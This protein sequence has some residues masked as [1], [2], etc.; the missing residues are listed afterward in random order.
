[1]ADWWKVRTA[2]DLSNFTDSE[3]YDDSADTIVKYTLMPGLSPEEIED[4]KFWGDYLRGIVLVTGGEGQGKG[5]FVH[6]LGY[7]LKRYFGINIVSDS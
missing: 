7:K 5:M 3:L 2:E 6:M 4:A 1:M